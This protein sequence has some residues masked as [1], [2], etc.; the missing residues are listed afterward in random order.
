MKDV[1]NMNDVDL[2]FEY[3]EIREKVI[4]HT[5]K[6]DEYDRLKV[7]EKEVQSRAIK[8]NPFYRINYDLDY[9]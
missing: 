4:N 2:A 9:K 1:K 3:R 6:K 8:G 5:A 7:L